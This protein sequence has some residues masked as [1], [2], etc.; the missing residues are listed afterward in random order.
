VS[1]ASKAITGALKSAVPSLIALGLGLAAGSVMMILF[2]LNPLVIFEDIFSGALGTQF[3]QSYVLSY[4]G[5]YILLALAF[6]IPGKAGIWNVGGQGQA[7]LGGIV[8]A[9][10]VVFVP[11]PPGIWAFVAILAACAVGAL[12]SSVSGFL[13][14]YRNASA[15]VTTIMLNFVA[16][17][18]ATFLLLLAIIPKVPVAAIYDRVDIS[19]A[20]T[21]PTLPYFNAS[22]MVVVAIIIAIGTYFFLGRTTLGY[23]IRATGLGMTQ[24]EAKGINPRR[25]KVIA[26]A[27]GGALAGLAGAGDILGVGRGCYLTACYQDGFVSGWFGGEG[28]AGIVVALMAANNPVGSI[29]T[30]LFVAI[31]ATGMAA[32]FQN[33]YPVWAM[34]GIIVL[35]MSAP[36]LSKSILNLRRGRGRKWI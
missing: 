11:L 31:L 28:F 17:A 8:V 35:L 12:W 3:G 15:I 21:L 18:F 19:P 30:G 32:V 26:M 9:L 27:I 10:I 23:R 7:T 1:R 13:E 20:A 33:I 14:A 29:F 4:L 2:G 6:L 22:I 34:Q 24:A 16:S 5:S 25:N 36:T